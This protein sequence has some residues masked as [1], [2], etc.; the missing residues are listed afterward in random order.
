[1]HALLSPMS[2]LLHMNIHIYKSRRMVINEDHLLRL[3]GFIYKFEISLLFFFEKR[4]FEKN[5]HIKLNHDAI[6]P[7]LKQRRHPTKC[8]CIQPRPK[9]PHRPK[10]PNRSNQSLPIHARPSRFLHRRRRSA[11]PSHRILGSMCPSYGG[12]H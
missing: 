12:A 4:I 10:H 11:S 8:R 6:H 2:D 9:G 7:Q 1:M 5:P 3:I